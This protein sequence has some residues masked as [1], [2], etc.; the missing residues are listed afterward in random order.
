MTWTQHWL[1][2]TTRA[3]VIPYV[4]DQNLAELEK[5]DLIICYVY[6]PKHLL[7][8]KIWMGLSFSEFCLELR[9]LHTGAKHISW[10]HQVIKLY[11]KPSKKHSKIV[12]K[13]LC[14]PFN[15]S[16]GGSPRNCHSHTI[17]NSKFILVLLFKNQELKRAYFFHFWVFDFEFGLL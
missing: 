17:S 13:I 6:W 3:L 12:Y 4:S 15:E 14:S 1:C 8:I 9:Q 2:H 10:G 16:N 11:H 7:L 5:S